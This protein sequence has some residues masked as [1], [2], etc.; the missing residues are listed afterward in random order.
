MRTLCWLLV[1]AHRISLEEY[2][3]KNALFSIDID[4]DVTAYTKEWLTEAALNEVVRL[5]VA[6]SAD[7]EGPQKARDWLQG[8]PQLV[9]ID[10][11]HQYEHT[12]RE[13]NRWFKELEPGGLLLLHDVSVFAQQFDAT[14][15]GGVLPAVQEWTEANGLS[16]LL[17][18]HFVDGTQDPHE[19]IYQDGC[20]LGLI[21]KPYV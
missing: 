10:S 1:F 11:S 15:A 9:F 14:K 21:Q 4:S 20:G 2:G 19:L 5:E 17:I 3:E 12:V 6:D 18:N 13:L 16:P 8:A 7:A